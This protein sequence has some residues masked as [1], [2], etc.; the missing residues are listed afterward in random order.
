MGPPFL[1]DS[2]IVH[3]ICNPNLRV[4]S[5]YI[6]EHITRNSTFITVPCKRSQFPLCWAIS[7]A[8]HFYLQGP[9]ALANVI[10]INITQASQR[11]WLIR[12]IKS[13]TVTGQRRHHTS[14]RSQGLSIPFFHPLF[15]LTSF[16]AHVSSLWGLI[17]RLLSL[18]ILSKFHFSESAYFL[19][20]PMIILK[21]HTGALI[22]FSFIYESFLLF[23]IELFF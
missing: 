22:S 12:K 2:Y 5:P 4:F 15:L 20:S 19:W 18:R 17:H 14:V 7:N 11:S 23:L 21:Y 16:I 3:K 13:V 9:L 10:L 8:S 6:Q 1:L